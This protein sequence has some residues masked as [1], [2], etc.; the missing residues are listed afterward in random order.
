M[1][2]DLSRNRYL[3]IINE[4]TNNTKPL[5]TLKKGSKTKYVEIMYKPK[6]IY[7]RALINKQLLNK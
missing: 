5:W 3:F 7:Q 1:Q 4:Q 2:E 6:W